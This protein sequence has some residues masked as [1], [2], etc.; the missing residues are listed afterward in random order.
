MSLVGAIQLAVQKWPRGFVV[1]GSAEFK[2]AVVKA[3]I[4]IGAAKRINNPEL[5]GL[6]ETELER[7]ALQRR[8]AR[9]S[10]DEVSLESPA[11]DGVTHSGKDGGAPR[12]SRMSR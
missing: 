3:A 9:R 6:I 7:R 2:A 8:A 11:A 4:E 1:R 12:R 5:Q 10:K